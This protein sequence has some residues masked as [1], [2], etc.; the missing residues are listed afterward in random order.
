MDN[1]ALLFT[2]EMALGFVN[3]QSK[4]DCM[5]NAARAVSVRAGCCI[6]CVFVRV[7]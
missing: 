1:E 2:A 5:R 7:T 4:H 3:T 6:I